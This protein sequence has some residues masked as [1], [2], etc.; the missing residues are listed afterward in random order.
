ML[1]W[2]LE[3]SDWCGARLGLAPLAGEEGAFA[4]AAVSGDGLQPQAVA[5][6][7]EQVVRLADA[8][9]QGTGRA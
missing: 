1:R 6:G 3:S 7:V 5:W 4:A 8:Y 2:M 9:D